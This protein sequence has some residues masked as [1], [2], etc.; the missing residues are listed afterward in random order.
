MTSQALSAKIAKT[1]TFSANRLPYWI[2]VLTSILTAATFATAFATPPRSGPFCTMSA[3]VTAPYTDV[4]AFFPRDYLWMYPALLVTALFVV[5]MACIHQYASADKQLFSLIGVC[6]AVI[7][8]AVLLID[9]FMQLTVMQPSVLKGET[10]GLSLV[11]QYNP[12][13]IFIALEALGYLMMSVAFVF[14][15]PVFTGRDWVERTIRWL[16]MAGFTLAVGLLIVLSLR[17]G[18]DLDYR[19]EVFV[20]TIDW[21]VLIIVGALLSVVFTRAERAGGQP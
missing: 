8:A 20:I 2:A 13:G 9:Y 16:L 14:A 6:F 3:C 5:L 1:A 4:A 17:Y 15:A 21:T 10:D 18:H 7:A 12:H 11:S 19:F